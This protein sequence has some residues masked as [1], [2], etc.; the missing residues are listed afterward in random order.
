[1][2]VM[3]RALAHRNYRLWIAGLF[4]SGIGTWMQM[5]AQDWTVL[6][7]LTDQDAGALSVVIALQTAPQLILLPISGYVSDRIPRRRL[8]IGTQIAMGLLAVTLGCLLLG[9][10][11]EYWHVCV[12]AAVTGAVQAFDSPARNTFGNELVHPG[13]LPNAIALGGATFNLARLVGPAIAGL[14]IGVVG[15]GWI[16]IANAVTFVAMLAGLGLMR[17]HEFHPVQ[18]DD[19]RS[20][21][22]LGG[23]RYVLRDRRVLALIVMVFLVVG[24]VGNSITLLI[25]TAATKEFDLGAAGFGL[26]TSCIAAGSIVGALFAAARRSPR[27]RVLLAAALGFGVALLLAAVMPTAE[28]F[29][30]SMPLVGFFLMA[31]MAT[32]NALVQTWTPPGMRGRVIGVYMLAWMG[33]APLGALSFGAVVEAAGPRV[34]LA[35]G[36]GV[37]ALCAVGV[38]L[39]LRSLRA[40]GAAAAPAPA[41][42]EVAP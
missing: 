42:S 17:A 27:P 35:V 32:V 33:G 40:S 39:R 6:T 9:G 4:I 34:A 7:V 1:M 13:V 10:V 2:R 14:L 23:I 29:A 15:P 19:G 5:T 36:G 21:R 20:G 11:A 38:G 3:F 18:R 28:A 24:F 25:I 37:A 30:I 8:L 22:W 26:L 41:V 16:F 31:A 12:L